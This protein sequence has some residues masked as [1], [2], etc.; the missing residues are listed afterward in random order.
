MIRK[1]VKA[2]ILIPLAIV[3][4]SL[5][6]A[7]R[8]VVTVSFDPFDQI[9][10]AF[11]VA[12]PLYVLIL[13]LVIAGVVI[14]GVAAWLRQGKWRWRA[15]LAESQA[16]DLQVEND[17]LKRVDPDKSVPVTGYAPRLTIP[18]STG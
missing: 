18:P 12:L 3:I 1:I 15:R 11:S 5:A 13:A 7:N 16:H 6:V 8:Q 2:F 4:V 9:H 10:P 17:R 14:G